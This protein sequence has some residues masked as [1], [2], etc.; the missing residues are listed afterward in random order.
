MMGLCNSRLP[1]SCS[2]EVEMMVCG[3]ARVGVCAGVAY[4]FVCFFN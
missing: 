1:W 4:R 3:G 2:G